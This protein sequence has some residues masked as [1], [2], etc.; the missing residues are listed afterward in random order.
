[1]NSRW[2]SLGV[3]MALSAVMTGAVG[4]SM[5]ST[6]DVSEGSVG[7]V[8]L[9]L[10]T[11]TQTTHRLH[12]ATFVV[13]TQNGTQV[14]SASSDTDPD[15]Q[16]LVVPLVQGTYSVKLQD[17][18]SL[19]SV[20]ADGTET[21]VHAALISQN[22]QSFVIH[23]ATDT[24]VTFMF[25]TD[26]GVVVI[27]NG[28]GNIEIGVTPNTGL[29]NCDPLSSY[30]NYCPTGQSCLLADATGRGFCAVTGSLPVGSPCSSEQCVAGAQ[31][32]ETDP[33]Q[34]GQAFCTKFCDTAASPFGC[35]CV[36]LGYANSNL[37]IC[38]APPAGSCNPIT[39]TGCATGEACQYQS[40]S[41]GTCGTAGT[42]PVGASCTGETC[43]A[44]AS[45]YSGVCRNYCD[46]SVWYT[47]G[48]YCYSA[49]TGPVGR[50]F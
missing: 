47:P 25:T 42:T 23:A 1:M 6:D 20:A 31:C 9:P 29:N 15:A 7:S 38:A 4:C 34:P 24:H 41:F 27:G 37:G 28:N 48:C 50:C 39:Q 2:I 36:S 43:V 26:S 21:P 22:P 16:A 19:D 11:P 17:G 18:W 3:A 8:S 13:S 35:N 49:G 10:V 40:G 14:A 30:Y 33:S 44:G 32:L 45:C 12:G 5:Q 46:T